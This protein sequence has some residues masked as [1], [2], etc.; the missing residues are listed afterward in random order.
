MQYG[1]PGTVEWPALCMHKTRAQPTT[2]LCRPPSHQSVAG[3]INGVGNAEW[4]HT[5][6]PSCYVCYQSLLLPPNR[7]SPAG[8]VNGIDTAEWSPATDAHLRG[9]G[10]ATYDAASLEGGKARCKAA[11][12]MVSVLQ[13]GAWA[14]PLQRS[15]RLRQTQSP[16]LIESPIRGSPV[17]G[18]LPSHFITTKP[19]SD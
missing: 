5:C 14:Q 13:R 12:Q 4:Y 11:L 19:A 2:F 3:V 9:G 6:L 15:S 1:R 7:Q 10:Y 8:V 17:L 18:L 16:P